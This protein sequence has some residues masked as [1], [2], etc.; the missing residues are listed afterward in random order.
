MPMTCSCWSCCLLCGTV[1]LH[2]AQMGARRCLPVK[3]SCCWSATAPAGEGR[4]ASLK[5][6]GTVCKLL[7]QQQTSLHATPCP[8]LVPASTPRKLSC[9]ALPSALRPSPIPSMIFLSPFLQPCASP[10]ACRLEKSSWA[11]VAS[12]SSALRCSGRVLKAGRGPTSVQN[13]EACRQGWAGGRPVRVVAARGVL[14][15]PCLQAAACQG[16][17]LRV[18][19]YTAMLHAM[20]MSQ[21]LTRTL[22]TLLT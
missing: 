18:P 21:H 12:S 14:V 16:T 13:L 20:P 17:P 15:F 11:S 19:I 10:P 3:T 8:R 7:A 4:A 22:V 2:P 5:A 6:H 1:S 9:A